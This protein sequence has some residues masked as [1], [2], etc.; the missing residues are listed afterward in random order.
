MIW[1]QVDSSTVSTAV[2][3]VNAAK[4]HLRCDYYGDQAASTSLRCVTGASLAAGSFM[5]TQVPATNINPFSLWCWWSSRWENLNAN[6]WQTNLLS[7]KFK[8]VGE[9][10]DANFASLRNTWCPTWV[11]WDLGLFV[12]LQWHRLWSKQ[13]VC[14]HSHHWGDSSTISYTFIHGDGGSEK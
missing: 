13:H 12:S 11:T 7:F 5:F 4:K 2:K 14:Y 6:W 3:G 8:Y 10:N 9:A 1:S